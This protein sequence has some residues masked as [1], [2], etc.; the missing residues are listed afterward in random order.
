[1]TP[2]S[3]GGAASTFGQLAS[4]ALDAQVNAQPLV[5]PGVMV[6]GDPAA[7]TH[8]VVYVVTEG[9]TVY[10]INPVTGTVLLSRNLGPPVPPQPQ[11]GSPIVGVG[12]MSTP[13]IDR[14]RSLLYLIAST[15]DSSGPNY[16]LH[17]LSLSTLADAVP[18]A[19]ISATQTLTNGTTYRFNPARER[20]R[21]ALLEANGAIYAGFG[22]YCDAYP[23]VARGWVMGW[24][25]DTLQ[26]LN[27]SGGGAILGELTDRA[28]TS[29]TGW[30]LSSVWMSG[31]GLAADALGIYFITGN[32]DRSGTA[33]DGVNNIENSVIKLSA[34]TATVLDLFTPYNVADLDI[35]DQDFASGGIMLLPSLGPSVPPLATAAGKIGTMYLLNRASLGGYT[36]GGPDKVFASEPIGR[37]WCTET[38]FAAPTPTVISSGGNAMYLWGVKT[39]PSIG[40]TKYAGAVLPASTANDPGFFTSVSSNGATQ[41]IIWAV[42]RPSGG[43]PNVTLLA[44]GT[45]PGTG[46]ALPLLYS[47]PAGTWPVPNANADIM[48][49]VANGRVYVAS[50]QELAI[51]GLGAAAR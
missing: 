27:V 30:F 1:L 9:N 21:P 37:C 49:V 16:R 34:S 47:A 18:P 40:L 25:A 20:Q 35:R 48:P 10:A 44:Y 38:Y 42:A 2:A 41:P 8:D 28:A 22:A 15:Q 19:V 39:K 29:P 36:P 4:V 14:S 51:F 50:Y 26:P 17:A 5:V 46:G 45:T 33:Y 32:S 31:A 11:C 7:G 12:I 6:S 13:V 3:V 43:S 24:T 23:A